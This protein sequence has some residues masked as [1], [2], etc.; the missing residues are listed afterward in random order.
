M[1]HFGAVVS[2]RVCKWHTFGMI[3]L[4]TSTSQSWEALAALT[5]GGQTELGGKGASSC[6]VAS[7]NQLQAG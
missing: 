5:A 7:D 3:G 2:D 4:S 1:A 6:E